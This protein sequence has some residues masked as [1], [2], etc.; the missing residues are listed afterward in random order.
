[1]REKKKVLGVC[2]GRESWKVCCIDQE[3]E[4]RDM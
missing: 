2:W 3:R 1:M 4:W